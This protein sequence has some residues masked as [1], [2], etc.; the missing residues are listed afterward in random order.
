[1]WSLKCLRFR[2]ISKFHL[3]LL[4]AGLGHTL[5][6]PQEGQA[7]HEAK[8]WQ[9]HRKGHVG[10]LEVHHLHHV[11]V[12][13]HDQG[14]EVLGEA[15]V[16]HVVV[17][18]VEVQGIVVRCQ[19]PHQE[20]EPLTCSTASST[21][22]DEDRLT[23]QTASIVPATQ[24]VA[25]Y[26][27]RRHPKASAEKDGL[28]IPR[29]VGHQQRP[30]ICWQSQ[31]WWQIRC[32]L[33]VYL[34]GFQGLALDPLSDVDIVFHQF[35][36]IW[37]RQPVRIR[38]TCQ[39][40]TVLHAI[41]DQEWLLMSCPHLHASPIIETYQDIC[42]VPHPFLLVWLPLEANPRGA[43]K[44]GAQT[45]HLRTAEHMFLCLPGIAHRFLSHF[46]VAQHRH[47]AL[48]NRLHQDRSDFHRQRH[49]SHAHS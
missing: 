33:G 27:R 35:S 25:H 44:S 29:V 45:A 38:V 48:R 28:R 41:I 12:G 46:I 7:R 36:E 19:H 39:F 10:P 49:V 16:I 40:S 9:Q 37:Q 8:I 24:V 1:M 47:I 34:V 5:G 13:H 4:V 17:R 15:T 3:A 30:Q 14:P 18:P 20:P 43:A 22:E 21:V 42:L 11:A 23:P 2:W 32:L 26:P 6:P 31:L